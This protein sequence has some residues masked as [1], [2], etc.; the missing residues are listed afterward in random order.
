[1]IKVYL[2]FVTEYAS[3]IKARNIIDLKFKDNS[4]LSDETYSRNE[5][6][7]NNCSQLK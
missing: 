7:L 1:M 6:K 4:P 3:V 2:K 5:S